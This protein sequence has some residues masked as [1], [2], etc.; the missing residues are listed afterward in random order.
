MSPIIATGFNTGMTEGDLIRL[1]R[2]LALLLGCDA[3]VGCARRR[4]RGRPP[5][6]LR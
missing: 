5:G 1:D 6:V 3:L 2:R 4:R